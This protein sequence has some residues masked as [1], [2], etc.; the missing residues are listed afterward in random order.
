GHECSLALALFSPDGGR[1]LTVTSGRSASG[2]GLPFSAEEEHGRPKGQAAGEAALRDPG[3]VG[4]DGQFGESG[5]MSSS[6]DFSGENPVARLWDARSGK[7]VAALR[8]PRAP[9]MNLGN[10]LA[11]KAAAA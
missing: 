2:S 8:K 7:E 6:G 3:V 11:D 9:A 1:V 10:P 4:R 5:S